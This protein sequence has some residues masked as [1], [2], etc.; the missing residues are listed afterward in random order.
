MADLSLDEAELGWLFASTNI[1]LMLGVSC[2][3]WFADWVGRKGT[4]IGAVAAFGV[5]TSLIAYAESFFAVLALHVV[6]GMGFGAA[7][8]VILLFVIDSAAPSKRSTVT[9][10]VYC[11][12]PLSGRPWR[13]LPPRQGT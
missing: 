13:S 2:G 5:L 12:T 1:G 3:G 8:P 10:M 7:M 6:A 9:T 11:G 4:F